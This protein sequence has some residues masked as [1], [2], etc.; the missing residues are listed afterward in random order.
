[1]PQADYVHYPSGVRVT[2]RPDARGYFRIRYTDPATGRPADARRSTWDEA[3]ELALDLSGGLAR[4]QAGQANH[5]H[6]PIRNLIN[7]HLHD[8]QGRFAP[9]T[10]RTHRSYL[11]RYVTDTFGHLPV[12][13]W[14]IDLTRRILDHAGA[15][16]LAANTRANLLRALGSLAETGR[17][18]GYLPAQAAPTTGIRTPRTTHVDLTDL[19]YGRDIDQ[20]ADA[21]T[22]YGEPWW[23][24]HAYLM[25]HSGLRHGEALGL[26]AGDVN[27]EEGTLRVERQITQQR[28]EIRDPKYGSK[29]V[30][31]YPAWLDDLM[32]DRVRNLEPHQHVLSLDNGHTMSQQ[33]ARERFDRAAQAAGWPA[34]KHGERQPWTPHTLRHYFCTWALAPHP[35]GLGL[36]VADVSRFAGHSNPAITWQVY[37]ASRPDRVG[38]AR[39][40]SREASR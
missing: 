39:E 5:S 28:K 26:Q 16:D 1:M 17:L 13:Q 10:L 12:E 37:V 35:D 24:L 2:R 23:A 21:L 38:R 27:L 29:R 14:D 9:Q 8:E 22:H 19:P 31:I 7:D 33:T 3:E 25:S 6:Q 15:D 40:A 32:A 18:L 20:L 36:D 30:T 34:R 11:G 4:R